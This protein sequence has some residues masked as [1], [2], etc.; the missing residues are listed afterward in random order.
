MATYMEDTCDIQAEDNKTSTLGLT[1]N[2][3]IKNAN[4]VSDVGITGSVEES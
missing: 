4:N 1:D 2:D 3:D